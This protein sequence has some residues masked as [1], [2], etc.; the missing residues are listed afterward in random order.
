[1]MRRVTRIYQRDRAALWPRAQPR[2][3]STQTRAALKALKALKGLPDLLILEI[4]SASSAV[5]VLSGFSV[6]GS[7]ACLRL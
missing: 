3:P 4:T 7:P 6:R 2:T 5:G 1:M